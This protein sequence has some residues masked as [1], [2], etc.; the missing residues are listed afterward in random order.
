MK[1]GKSGKWRLRFL[2]CEFLLNLLN[3]GERRTDRIVNS[4][5]V[6]MRMSICFQDIDIVLQ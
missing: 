4:R 3:S 6:P 1:N 5:S 2:L